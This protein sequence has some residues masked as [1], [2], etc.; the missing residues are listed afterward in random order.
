MGLILGT[1]LGG[2]AEHLEQEQI[3]R[4]EEI[5]HFPRLDGAGAQRVGLFAAGGRPL[6][7]GDGGRFHA[8]KVTPREQITLPV[9]VMRAL[10]VECSSSRTPPGGMN[11]AF[12]QATS[13]VIEDHINLMG[14]IR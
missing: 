6:G 1:G 8:T 10:G 13:M 7:D 2:F 11:P 4:Y 5:P 3:I 12:A 9:R 14:E